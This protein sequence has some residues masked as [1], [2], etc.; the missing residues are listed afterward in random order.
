MG[1]SLKVRVEL[2]RYFAPLMPEGDVASREKKR[3]F[4]ATWDTSGLVGAP[5]EERGCD[6]R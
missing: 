1:T 2:K 6:G 3:K 5:P 4:L